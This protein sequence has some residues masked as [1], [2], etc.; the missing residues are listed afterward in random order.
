MKK[1]RTADEVSRNGGPAGSRAE[2]ARTQGIAGPDEL[3]SRRRSA[4]SSGWRD[5]IRGMA[6][7]DPRDAPPPGLDG[8]S[9]AGAAAPERTGPAAA[10]P[11]VKAAET[12][13]RAEGQLQ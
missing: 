12:R 3:T 11:A 10:G 13:A 5:G 4:R 9:Q 8:A 7:A 1:R 6:M 2:P